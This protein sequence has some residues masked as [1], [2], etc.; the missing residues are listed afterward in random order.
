MD[1]INVVF[2]PLIRAVALILVLLTCFAYLTWYERKLLARFQVRYGPNRAGPKG[3]LQPIADAVKAMFKEEIIPNH[4][5]KPIYLLGPALALIPA[6]VI[7]GVIPVSKGVPAMA[8]VNIGFLWI[9]AI[10]GVES[11]GLILAGWSSNNNYSLLGALRSSAQMI[12][13]ELPLGLFLVS[14]LMLAG[15]FSLVSLVETPRAWWE[16]I[17]LWLMFPLFFICILAETNR[18]PFDLPETENEL[19]AGYQTEYGGIKFSLFM[20]AEYINM[21][22]TSTIMA[23]LF[24]GGYRLPFGFLSDVLWLGPFVLAFKVIILLFIFIWVRASIGRPRYD[25][26]M[27]FTWKFLLPVG[28]V[29]MII[30]ALLVVA[31]K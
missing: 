30:T 27:R 7:W 9:L 5:D 15:S 20:M 14:I 10:A 11:Y 16:W 25:Q 31:F 6:L 18:S 29:Y 2:I 28:I 13:Y 4:V 12:S 26:L 1:W 3:L 19:V 24:F 21:I 22:T 8:D 17:W 23:T